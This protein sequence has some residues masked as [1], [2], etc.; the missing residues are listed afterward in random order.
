MVVAKRL[1]QV[2]LKNIYF[3]L[4]QLFM[5]RRHSKLDVSFVH[6]FDWVHERM[7]GSLRMLLTGILKMTVADGLETIESNIKRLYIVLTA[8]DLE[9]KE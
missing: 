3:R 6:N 2:R 7:R 4:D 8:D 5:R 1:R 9:P